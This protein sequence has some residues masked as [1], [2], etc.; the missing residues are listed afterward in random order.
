MLDV[1]SFLPARKKIKKIFFFSINLTIRSFLKLWTTLKYWKSLKSDWLRCISRLVSTN[2]SPKIQLFSVMS[3]TFWISQLYHNWLCLH[4]QWDLQNY[5]SAFKPWQLMD[6]C[7]IYCHC[8]INSHRC[9]SFSQWNKIWQQQQQQQQGSS[10]RKEWWCWWH[11]QEK[12]SNYL[13]QLI[14]GITKKDQSY[15][16]MTVAD[17]SAEIHYVGRIMDFNVMILVPCVSTPK[18]W[19]NIKDCVDWSDMIQE[20]L[21]GLPSLYWFAVEKMIVSTSLWVAMQRFWIHLLEERC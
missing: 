18:S 21:F 7:Q 14:Q 15:E 9:Y 4:H 11:S 16:R 13:Q 6:L 8:K 17:N 12:S 3:F 19:W 20:E 1:G 2:N 5:W 10:K